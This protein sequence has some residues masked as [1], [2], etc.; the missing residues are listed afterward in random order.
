MANKKFPN[1]D[2]FVRRYGDQVEKEI[3]TRLKSNGKFASGK[4]YNSIR[5]EVKQKAGN[6]VLAFYMNE[7]GKYV[8]KGVTGSGVPNGFKGKLKKVNRGQKD[9]YT[10]KTYAYKDKMPPN[11]QEFKSW[12]RKRGIPKEKNFA[13]RR[14][15]YIFGIEPTNFFTIPTTRR[16]KYFQSELK[17]NMAKDI[18]ATINKEMNGSNS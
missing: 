15:I 11:N 10:K 18:D 1:T 4:L 14:S 12:M 6:I 13:V 3:K 2:A 16:L 8:D 5:S 9:Q 7:Y 17:K